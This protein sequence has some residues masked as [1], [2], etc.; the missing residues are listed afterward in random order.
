[1]INFY[2]VSIP[3]K[4][5]GNVERLLNLCNGKNGELALLFTFMYQFTFIL[6]NSEYKEYQKNYE[7][8]ISEKMLA[9][10]QLNE[11]LKSYGLT[12][13]QV[14]KR[15]CFLFNQS[16]DYSEKFEN[17]ISNNIKRQKFLINAYVNLIKQTKEENKVLKKLVKLAI[18]HK[19]L[20]ECMQKKK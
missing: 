4:N 16:I 7:L 14:K 1:M 6:E 19:R 2:Q 3:N 18:K 8:I 12:L 9:Y 17:F 5:K 15:D 20:F 13:Y 10:K 11:L